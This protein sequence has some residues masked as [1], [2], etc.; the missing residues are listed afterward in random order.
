MTYTV[1]IID[2][3]QHDPEKD[4]TI[5]GF[6]TL[7][8]AKEFASRWTRDSIEEFRKENSSPEN[9]RSEWLMFGEHAIALGAN[10][11]VHDNYFIMPATAE[12]RDWK[13]I[14]RRAGLEDVK[15]QENR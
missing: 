9:V 1:L 14:Q 15:Q 6:P 8:L 7:E 4:W 2:N 3:F 11:R 12:E 10:E 13:E 5:N